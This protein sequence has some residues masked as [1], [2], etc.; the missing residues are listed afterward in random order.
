MHQFILSSSDQWTLGPLCLVSLSLSLDNS[1]LTTATFFINEP[2]TKHSSYATYS[3]SIFVL[4][5]EEYDSMYSSIMRNYFYSIVSIKED[6]NC[7]RCLISSLVPCFRA[8]FPAQH[9][10]CKKLFF[11][12]FPECPHFW[13]IRNCAIVLLLLLNVVF[14]L[15]I[16]FSISLCFSFQYG[17]VSGR[18]FQRGSGVLLLLLCVLL[19]IRKWTRQIHFLSCNEINLWHPLISIWYLFSTSCTILTH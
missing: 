13:S 16:K 1:F 6:S 19:V 15:S 18:S 5:S 7:I 11:H 8:P 3:V 4:V 14:V 9:F 10:C 17:L 2:S 12:P